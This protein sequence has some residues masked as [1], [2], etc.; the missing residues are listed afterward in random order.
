MTIMHVDANSAY[1]SWTAI[2]LLEKGYPIDLRTVPAAIAG[3][4]KDRHGIILAKSIPA[5]K[6]KVGTGESL[7]ESMQRCPELL[8]FPPNYD[9]YLSCSQ[10]MYELL[11][12]Y[13]PVIQRYSVDECFM[14]FSRCE[15][16]QGDPVHVAHSLKERIKEELGFTVNIGVAKSKVMA[17]M[18]G[19]LKKPD[20][21][22]SL[23]TQKEIEEKLWPLP[24]GELF[25][26]GRASV[27]KL[28]RMNINTIGDLAG[29]EVTLLRTLLK[30][31][32]QLIWEY[33]NG[34]DFNRVIPNEEILQKGLSNGLTIDHDVTNQGEAQRYLLSLT[35]RVAG[36]LRRHGC[37]A[38]LVRISVKTGSFVY[39]THQLKLPFFMDDTTK[40]YRY[41]C[42]LFDECWK[43]EPIR[44]LGVGVSE[45]VRKDEY[46]L[47]VFELAGIEKDEAMMGII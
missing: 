10:A 20:Q 27:K 7:F 26:V 3:D 47:S 16:V 4:P 40:I 17:K 22:H 32:G 34:I 37:K 1:L 28:K 6:Y 45:F 23:L 18:A 25:M 14:D 29:S 42:R 21:V 39:Y 44:Q 19:E 35:E 33:A 13:S 12:E 46:Q 31:H 30:S 43:G 2:D 8:V 9:L 15:H 24:V 11:L 36:R 5:K 41:A 38:S